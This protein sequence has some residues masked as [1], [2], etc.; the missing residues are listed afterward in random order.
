[1]SLETSEGLLEEMGTQALATGSY[2][3]SAEISK[4]IDSVSLTDVSNV[5]H[6]LRLTVTFGGDR[7]K[8]VAKAN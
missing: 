7:P 5:S 1:M 8:L 2:C 4:K 6:L 3:P